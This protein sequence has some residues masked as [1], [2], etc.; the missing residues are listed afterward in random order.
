MAIDSTLGAPR[1]PPGVPGGSSGN[2]LTL[3]PKPTLYDTW[4]HL[5][6][7]SKLVY[8][9]CK[10]KKMNAFGPVFEGNFF[11]LYAKKTPNFKF[12]PGDLRCIF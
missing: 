4:I 6:Q 3:L 11:L 1:G 7:V 8:L 10:E 12:D 9:L 5:L 2:I